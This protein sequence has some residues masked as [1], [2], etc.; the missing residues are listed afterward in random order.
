MAATASRYAAQLK[1]CEMRYV[2]LS[3]EL[4]E[5][6]AEE[7]ILSKKRHKIKSGKQLHTC[8]CF[9]IYF[10]FNHVFEL[11]IIFMYWVIFVHYFEF[12]AQV[13][14]YITLLHSCTASE[15]LLSERAKL[16]QRILLLQE[17]RELIDR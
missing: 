12:P 7:T 5:T 10:F 1:S 9:T 2:I 6:T 15:H 4:E 3:N 11:F 13:I 16:D 14:G 8:V 17:E